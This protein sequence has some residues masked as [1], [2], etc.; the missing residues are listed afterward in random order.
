MIFTSRWIGVDGAGASG[1]F[2]N[3]YAFAGVL[4]G[5]LFLRRMLLERS[6]FDVQQ[7]WNRRWSLPFNQ[8]DETIAQM[9]QKI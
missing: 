8:S 2:H 6:F 7:L 1:R 4:R 9:I 3:R 5:G